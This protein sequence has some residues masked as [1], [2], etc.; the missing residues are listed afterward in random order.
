MAERCFSRRC[1]RHNGMPEHINAA[2]KVYSLRV[3]LRACDTHGSV[4]CVTCGGRGHYSAFDCGHF[5][6]RGN[7]ATRFDDR[8]TAVQCR[9]CNRSNEGESGKFA[10][11]IDRLY[12]EG[13]SNT[14]R[15]LARQVCKRATW[16]VKEMARSFRSEVAS[17][18][19]EKGL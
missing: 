17:L 19:K 5:M 7:Q 18:K 14:L 11:Y 16:E 1:N 9:I 3:R 2:D 4:S 12:G 8:N 15:I 6:P 10:A 13:T